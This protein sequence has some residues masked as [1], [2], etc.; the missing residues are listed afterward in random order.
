MFQEKKSIQQDVMNQMH[1][2][3]QIKFALNSAEEKHPDWPTDVIHQV[4]IMNEEAGESIRA[5]LQF[6]Y[7]GGSIKDVRKE[8]LHT[9]AMCLRCLKNLPDGKP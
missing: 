5:A 6:V 3:N 9:A 8:L 1:Y 2:L 7:E 4:S